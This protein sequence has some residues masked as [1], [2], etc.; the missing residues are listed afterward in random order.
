MAHGFA[1][2]A[3]AGHIVQLP[4]QRHAQLG[5]GLLAGRKVVVRTCK[6]VRALAQRG[7]LGR[8]GTMRAARAVPTSLRAGQ[9]LR[10]LDS[11][12]TEAVLC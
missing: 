7:R 5:S 6:A 8:Q 1:V 12:E 11:G 3:D 10:L 4:G 2:V 9:T